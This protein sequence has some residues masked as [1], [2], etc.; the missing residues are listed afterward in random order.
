MFFAD[1]QRCHHNPSWSATL[2]GKPSGAIM[3]FPAGHP[4]LAEASAYCRGYQQNLLN[5]HRTV[6]GP[7]LMSDLIKVYPIE[8]SDRD[9]FYPIRTR[10]VWQFGEPNSASDVNRAVDSSPTVHWFKM[11]GPR[12]APRNATARWEF[13]RGRVHGAWRRP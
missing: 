6:V 13:P 8:V 12:A 3:R 10:H 9:L 4:L 5:S 1:R 7:M 11:F 2:R